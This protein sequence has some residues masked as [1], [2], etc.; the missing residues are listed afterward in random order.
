MCEALS[1]LLFMMK[2][3]ASGLS[4][5][6]LRKEQNPLKICHAWQSLVQNKQGGNN[7]SKQ[8]MTPSGEGYLQVQSSLAVASTLSS[9]NAQSQILA[10]WPQRACTKRADGC[11][12][13]VVY[14]QMHTDLSAE[15]DASRLPLGDQATLSG[16]VHIP[17]VLD[18]HSAVP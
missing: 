13:V 15:H 4:S 17:S 14:D 7:C 18:A 1:A 10:V 16:P 8:N 9:W 5:S 3:I 11:P 6:Q 2:R 12:L